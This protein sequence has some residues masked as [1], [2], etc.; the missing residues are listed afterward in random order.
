MELQTD[1]M[2]YAPIKLQTRASPP[3]SPF[4]CSSVAVLISLTTRYLIISSIEMT[5]YTEQCFC[6][7]LKNLEKGILRLIRY[8]RLSQQTED[9]YKLTKSP[10]IINS[11]EIVPTFEA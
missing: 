11:P 3:F 2:P 10:K 7:F 9:L 6:F 1:V 8:L 5:N 4:R